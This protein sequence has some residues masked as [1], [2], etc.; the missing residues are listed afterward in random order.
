MLNELD[1]LDEAIISARAALALLRPTAV[2]RECVRAGGR[3]GD[4]LSRRGEWP[5]AASAFDD[6]V[7][8]SELAFHA[9]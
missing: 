2:P 5:E 3:L 4:L 7:Q 6:A 1:Q 9:A 8:A